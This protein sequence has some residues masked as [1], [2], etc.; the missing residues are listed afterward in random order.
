M[1]LIV[2]QNVFSSKEAH[3]TFL[4]KKIKFAILEILISSTERP[5][6]M[7]TSTIQGFYSENVISKFKI[8]FIFKA[9][10]SN[11]RD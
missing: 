3:V 5:W 8:Y 11:N 2:W 1:I 10:I 4:W 7:W 6:P 9:Q